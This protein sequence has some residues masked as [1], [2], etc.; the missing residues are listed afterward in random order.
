MDW[1]DESGGS[2]RL[3]CL[4]ALLLDEGEERRR[5]GG[6]GILY[7]AIPRCGSVGEGNGGAGGCKKLTGRDFTHSVAPSEK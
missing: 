6:N 7:I 5:R 3:D 2:V 1:R 4:M